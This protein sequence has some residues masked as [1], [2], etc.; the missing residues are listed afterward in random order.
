MYIG[1]IYDKNH[2]LTIALIYLKMFPMTPTGER[3][4]I[5]ALDYIQ[6]LSNFSNDWLFTLHTGIKDF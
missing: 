3:P 1:D 6:Q 2:V 4:P 5:Q